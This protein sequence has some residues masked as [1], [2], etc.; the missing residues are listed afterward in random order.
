[1]RREP[2]DLSTFAEAGLTSTLYRLAP[3]SQRILSQLGFE[4]NT[5]KVENG[6]NSTVVAPKTDADN[7]RTMR[8]RLLRA[9]VEISAYL[10]EHRETQRRE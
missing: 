3:S 6:P 8:A 2:I 1:M 5:Q 4:A 10:E 9:W 7:L